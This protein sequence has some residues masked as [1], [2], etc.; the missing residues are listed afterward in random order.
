MRNL[1]LQVVTECPTEE[2]K[3]YVSNRLGPAL[4]DHVLRPSWDN[5]TDP[6]WTNNN[7]ESINHVLKQETKWQPQHTPELIETLYGVYQLQDKELSRS[8]IGRGNYILAPRYAHHSVDPVMWSSMDPK[9]KLAKIAAFRS[10]RRPDVRGTVLST[11]GNLRVPQAKS[12]GKK[13]HQR[14]R[15]R[16]E[17]SADKH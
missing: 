13:P 11:D 1:H 12:A 5:K 14:R 6:R 9:L 17:R 2:L 10:K 15:Q 16:A 8:L 3:N 7:A 4:R